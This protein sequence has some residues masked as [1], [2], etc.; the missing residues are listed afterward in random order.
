[1]QAQNPYD[2]N[3][4]Q[5]LI[6]STTAPAAGNSVN[7]SVPTTGRSELLALSFTFTTDANAAD[8]FIAIVHGS[9]AKTLT[10]AS[11][12]IAHTASLAIFWVFAPGLV[13]QPAIATGRALCALPAY[14]AIQPGDSLTAYVYG[15]QAA[16]TFT[17]INHMFKVWPQP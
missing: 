5:T 12:Y 16:D 4:F 1:M 13:N 15:I 10:I 9:A 6:G 11:S 14:P 17:V 2:L 7:L 8:R 3:L